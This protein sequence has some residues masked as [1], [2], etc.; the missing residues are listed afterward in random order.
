MGVDHPG[1]YFL[2]SFPEAFYKCCALHS[3]CGE[4][5]RATSVA[6]EQVSEKL[7]FLRFHCCGGA[8]SALS[9][10]QSDPIF[11]SAL[12]FGQMSNLF[13]S[14]CNA[15]FPLDRQHF[16]FLSSAMTWP[17]YVLGVL[18][19]TIINYLSREWYKPRKL[20][21]RPSLCDWQYVWKA[22]ERTM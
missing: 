14:Q 12:K 9:L 11:G 2:H 22:T 10:F 6:V 19:K 16:T 15:L 4:R 13:L 5:W 3:R 1:G 20:Q 8:V 21:G 17:A 7:V 18:I